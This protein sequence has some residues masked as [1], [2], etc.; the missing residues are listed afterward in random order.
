MALTVREVGEADAGPLGRDREER[1]AGLE[2]RRAGRATAATAAFLVAFGKGGPAIFT[3]RRSLAFLFRRK[4]RPLNSTSSPSLSVFLTLG[5][6]GERGGLLTFAAGGWAGRRR[7]EKTIFGAGLD[8][9][10]EEEESR[11]GAAAE[12][13]EWEGRKAPPSRLRRSEE[14]PT[15]PLSAAKGSEETEVFREE[16]PFDRADADADLLELFNVPPLCGVGREEI[17]LMILT[18]KLHLPPRNWNH[19]PR[20]RVGGTSCTGP[21]TPGAR[22][23]FC[24]PQ[25]RVMCDGTARPDDA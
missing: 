1:F 22:S 3:Q 19:E 17:V 20:G 11:P 7:G 10:D 25:T 9:E 21:K 13:G 12:R 15:G 2:G 24:A 23:P 4:R 18:Y 16:L 8:R 5:T 6:S 14:L